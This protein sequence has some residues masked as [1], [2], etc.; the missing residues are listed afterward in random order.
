[1]R[2]EKSS[3]ELHLGH[4]LTFIQKDTLPG[5]RQAVR[6]EVCRSVGE[7][8]K[9][10]HICGNCGRHAGIHAEHTLIGVERE[11]KATD[12]SFTRFSLVFVVT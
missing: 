4:I 10:H 6:G 2:F 11:V 1:M 3:F 8:H 7:T 9:E 12:G 5:L